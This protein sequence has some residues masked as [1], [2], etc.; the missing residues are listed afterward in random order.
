[1]GGAH[2]ILHFLYQAVNILFSAVKFDILT[3]GVYGI[4]SL[5]EPASTG[6]SMNCRF[7]HFRVGFARESGRLP[8]G[9]DSIS[10]DTGKY[11]YALPVL[12]LLMEERQ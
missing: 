2:L 5:L 3:W 12:A 6:Q 9:G 4:D 7:S 10:H 8:L 11:V 1:M